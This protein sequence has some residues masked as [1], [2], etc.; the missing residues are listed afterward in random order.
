MKIPKVLLSFLES[1]LSAD[2]L[3]L[4]V[5]AFEQNTNIRIATK[6]EDTEISSPHTSTAHNADSTRY[7]PIRDKRIES[8]PLVLRP[9]TANKKNVGYVV[10]LDT[11]KLSSMSQCEDFA[12]VYMAKSLAG[13]KTFSALSASLFGRQS[14]EDI[15]NN[16]AQKEARKQSERASLLTAAQPFIMLD[17]M[18]W[19]SIKPSIADRDE[20][21]AEIIEELRSEATA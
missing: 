16:F 8:V 5:R 10:V 9:V 7:I 3:A 21:L 20:S 6:D 18:V 17:A 4:A 12:K 15:R 1:F 11:D 14:G 2:W 19:E 13:K